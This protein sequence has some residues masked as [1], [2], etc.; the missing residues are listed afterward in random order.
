M[1]NIKIIG[2]KPQEVGVFINGEKL[3]QPIVSL[4]WRMDCKKVL[5][6]LTLEVYAD[7]D[8]EIEGEAIVSLLTRED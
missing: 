8:V 6:L 1:T 2:G 3:T 7:S 5:P 4:T